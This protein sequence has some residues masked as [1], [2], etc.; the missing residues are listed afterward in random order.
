M[1]VT[2]DTVRSECRRAYPSP[3]WMIPLDTDRIR[4]STYI[5]VRPLVVC[6]Y[7]HVPL[8]ACLRLMYNAYADACMESYSDS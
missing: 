5:S 7:T 8:W 2:R 3:T 4:Y 1:S 6:S